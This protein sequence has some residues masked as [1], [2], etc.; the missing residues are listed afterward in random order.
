[1]TN[2]VPSHPRNDVFPALAG[3]RST[4][5][6]QLMPEAL[7]RVHMQERHQEAEHQRLLRALRLRRKAEKVAL[8]AR[9]ALAGA[10]M[11]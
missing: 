5:M 3:S 2:L 11:L 9:R 6:Q 1:M 8:K 10:V 4:T 7:A